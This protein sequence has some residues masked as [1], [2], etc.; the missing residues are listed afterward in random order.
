M[1]HANC[2]DKAV[3]GGF[4]TAE[5]QYLESEVEEETLEPFPESRA[6]LKQNNCGKMA[7]TGVSFFRRNGSS[8]Q[9]GGSK[10]LFAQHWGYVF[11]NHPRANR[12]VR[13]NVDQN[14][15]A[16]RPVT[17]VGIKKQ[18]HVR[19]EFNGTDFIH[20]QSIGRL[21]GQGIDVDAMTDMK[22]PD[23]RLPGRVFDKV[24]AAQFEGCPV[25]P[26]DPGMKFPRDFGQAIRRNEHVAPAQVDLV[27][28]L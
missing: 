23:L 10:F 3:L 5:M 14:E 7:M 1:C 26:N 13:G 17:G 12:G 11:L 4:G 15:T 27:I 22:P 16:C 21:F 8:I 19:L 18:G 28:Q 24:S 2:V 6:I 20:L 9:S 25:K